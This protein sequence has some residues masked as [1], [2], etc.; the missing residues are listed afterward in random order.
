MFVFNTTFSVKNSRLEEWN[1]WI[2][3]A[4]LPEIGALLITN[5]FE[6]FEVMMADQD[7]SRT[8]SV[9]WRCMIPEHLEIINQ[10]STE[11]YNQLPELFGEECL[12]FSTVLK[13]Y[14]TEEIKI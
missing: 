13:E 9:Q 11:L 4:Y 8:F 6:I 1:R 10:K 5:G 7:D 2:N 14:K 3:D 12:H